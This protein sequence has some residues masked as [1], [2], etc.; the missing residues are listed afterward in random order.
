MAFLRLNGADAGETIPLADGQINYLTE[1]S[2]RLLEVKERSAAEGAL[3]RIRNTWVIL[4]F[5]GYKLSINGLRVADCKQV[6]EGDQIRFG[7]VNAQLSQ[8]MRRETV[9]EGSPLLDS[10]RECFFDLE[11]F[12]IGAV[13][14]YCPVCNTPYHADCWEAAKQTCDQCGYHALQ[15]GSEA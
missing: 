8:D 11:R 12:E 1:Q 5:S 2:G 4:D 9:Q 13:V 15:K 6:H 10:K 7:S 14:V 3:V